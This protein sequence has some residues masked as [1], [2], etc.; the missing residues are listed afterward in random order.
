MPGVTL[1]AGHYMFVLRM[2]VGGQ[3]IVDI[4]RAGDAAHVASC[5]AVEVK[6]TGPSAAA[7]VNYSGVT[8]AALKSWFVGG[9]VIGFQFVYPPSE[10]K[11]IYLASGEPVPFGTVQTI[12][13]DMVGTYG[14]A[15]TGESAESLHP[16]GTSGGIPVAPL[17][18]DGAGHLTAARRALADRLATQPADTQSQTL[19]LIELLDR[20][21]NAY[22]AR[23]ARKM[24]EALR[25]AASTIDGV[26]ASQRSRFSGVPA[27]PD[28]VVA[29]VEKARAHLQAFSKLA[30]STR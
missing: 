30:A 10:A 28:D 20:V 1:D 16:V 26:L 3:A 18:L 22:G 14:V 15:M 27:L 4:Y 13:P 21:E 6:R 25:L 17:E 8:P 12:R 11:T 2:P 19:L 7:F 29:A 5:L 23:D 9:S 24:A